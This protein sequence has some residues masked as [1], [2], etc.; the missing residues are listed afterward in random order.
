M[1]INPV[2]V[3]TYR[4]A[5]VQRQA[6]NKTVADN[7]SQVNATPVKIPNDTERTGSA[8]SVKLKEGTFT[9]MLSVE[10]KQ[11]LEMLFDKY[12]NIK[13]GDYSSNGETGR[14]HLGNLVDVKL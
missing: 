5:M 14:A 12:N 2:G 8:L 7:K 1:K 4:Q 11:A 6:D 9:D 10:E 13:Q 3:E